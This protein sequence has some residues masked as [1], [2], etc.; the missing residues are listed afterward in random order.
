M[1]AFLGALVVAIGIAIVAAILSDSIDLLSR[2]LYQSHFG[3][4][5]LSDR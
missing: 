1:R 5:R 3:S 4:V 2:D